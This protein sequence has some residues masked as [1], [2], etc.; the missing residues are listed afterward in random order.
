MRLIA[1][2]GALLIV[3]GVVGG[4]VPREASAQ[5]IGPIDGT[6]AVAVAEPTHGLGLSPYVFLIVPNIADVWTTK[7]AMDR[8][9]V[10]GSPLM[11]NARFSTIVLNKLIW[12][13]SITAAVR[14]L[15]RRGHRNWARGLAF[16]GGGA[17]GFAAWH[18]VG[19]NTQTPR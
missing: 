1:R 9:A 14:L 4:G 13:G 19:V 5:V 16:V 12:V 11:P 7:N 2:V 18:N 3:V 6:I 8:G 17:A 15:D 10:E